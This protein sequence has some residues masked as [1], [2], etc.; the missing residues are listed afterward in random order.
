ML[1]DHS[2][3]SDKDL[4]VWYQEAIDPTVAAVDHLLGG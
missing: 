1:L 3:G 4:P 2:L